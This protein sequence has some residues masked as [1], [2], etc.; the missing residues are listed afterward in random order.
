MY[1]VKNIFRLSIPL[2]LPLSLVL[3]NSFIS[4]KMFPIEDFLEIEING[5]LIFSRVN[6]GQD[7]DIEEIVEITKWGHRVST[8]I[9]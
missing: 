5:K 3:T 1:F 6:L 2:H 7:P 9:S 8:D 4:Y